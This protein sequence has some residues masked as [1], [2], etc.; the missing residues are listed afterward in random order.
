MLRGV[1]VLVLLMSATVAS[2]DDLSRAEQLAWNKQFAEAEALY[3]MLPPS[4]RAQL[5]L[6]RVVLWRGRYAEAVD[7]FNELLRANASDTDALEGR[8]TAAYWSGD[9][10]SAAR[11]F[12]RVLELDAKR[13]F[14]RTSLSE[15][16]STARPSQRIEFGGVRD[17]QPLDIKRAE[18]SATLFSD[19]LTRWTVVLGGAHFD[20]EVRGTRDAELFRVENETRWRD[21]TF[22]AA[23]G[24]FD[25]D[26]IGHAGVRWKQLALRIDRQAEVA[27]ATAIRNRAFST[28]TTLRWS[29]ERNWI[30]AIEGSHR[31]YSDDNS[32][33]AVVAYAVAPVWESGGKPP[34]STWTLWA[35][36]SAA[37]R[38]TDE[39]RFNVTSVSSTLED[40]FF[41]YRYRGEYDP[42]W[43]P[44]DLRE[45][46]AVIALE[47]S[48]SRGHV[49]LHADAGLARDRGR[50]FGPD[51]GSGPFPPQIFTFAFAR[52]YNPYRFGVAADVALAH[53]FRI[54]AGAERS[55][56]VDYRS[57]SF[58][59]ALVRRR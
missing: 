40:G 59:A 7:R 48:F 35:G 50:A 5:G 34:H 6:A 29:R 26:F 36:G 42:Y 27:S 58:H 15:I 46:R 2:A 25:G 14:A 28:T 39:S 32:G 37:A 13:E 8:A 20:G 49:K 56:T 30:A 19:P 17:D 47:R 44:D 4:R 54:E 9:Y 21:F 12:R 11:D 33:Y 18:V 10:R 31:A 22:G 53:G 16:A 45:A 38:D 23:A 3:R 52:D 55:V 57:T 41:R 43:T 24:A 1:G 51:T